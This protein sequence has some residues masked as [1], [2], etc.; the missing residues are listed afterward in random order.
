MRVV[1]HVSTSVVQRVMVAS[2]AKRC[3]FLSVI[4]VHV[5]FLVNLFHHP[6]DTIYKTS[7]VHSVGTCTSPRVALNGTYVLSVVYVGFF[8]NACITV[9][10]LW[11]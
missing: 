8:M 10:S 9:G 5:P 7:E 11:H 3:V 4:I 2:F 1:S 6:C